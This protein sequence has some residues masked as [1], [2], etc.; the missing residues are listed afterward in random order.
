MKDLRHLVCQPFHQVYEEFLKP[1]QLYNEMR[2]IFLIMM[3]EL[4]RTMAWVE[5]CGFELAG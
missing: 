1:S 5:R 3:M 2:Q 4:G